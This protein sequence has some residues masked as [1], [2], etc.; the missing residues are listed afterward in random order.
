[1]RSQMFFMSYLWPMLEI[2][3]STILARSWIERLE[4]RQMRVL[5]C[6]YFESG[7]ATQPSPRLTSTSESGSPV[8]ETWPTALPT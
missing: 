7:R 2:M 5:K 3:K 1:M 4:A 6:S 8:A